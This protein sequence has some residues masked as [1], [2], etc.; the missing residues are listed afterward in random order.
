[1]NDFFCPRVYGAIKFQTKDDK[2]EQKLFNDEC[3]DLLIA[4]FVFPF[5]L[6]LVL[7]LNLT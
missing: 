3:G 1:M 4:L 5:A 7:L 2:H 6:L